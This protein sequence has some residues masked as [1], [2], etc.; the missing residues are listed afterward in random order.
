MELLVN[1]Y[2]PLEVRSII[3][4]F[5]GEGK[6]WQKSRECLKKCMVNFVAMNWQLEGGQ[7]SSTRGEF[8]FKKKLDENITRIR[9]LLNKVAQLH[10][11]D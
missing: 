3:W 11:P 5:A 10:Y 4:F 1:M 7:S 2:I 8:V 9:T 6:W